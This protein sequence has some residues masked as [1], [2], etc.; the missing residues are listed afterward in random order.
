MNL[1]FRDVCGAFRREPAL[2]A[3]DDEIGKQR[4]AAEDEVR[5]HLG[6]TELEPAERAD[7]LQP[8]EVGQG[9]SGGEV[10]QRVT[11]AIHMAVPV[12]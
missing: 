2:T 5:E 6:E 3:S 11:Q 9:L 8:R 7:Y 1:R 10:V 4:D 12:D